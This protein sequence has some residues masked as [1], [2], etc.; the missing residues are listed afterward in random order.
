M[1]TITITLENKDTYIDHDGVLTVPCE[2]QKVI[3]SHNELTSLI[4]P[5]GIKMLDCTYNELT[6]LVVPK[7][8]QKLWCSGNK[9]TSLIVPEGVQELLCS[10]N[11]LTSLV[12]PKGIRIFWCCWNKLEFLELPD[13]LVLLNIEGNKK[14]I[15][16]PKEYHSK[17]PSE[18]MEYCKEH[19]FSQKLLFP[20][21]W[22]ERWNVIRLMYIAHYKEDLSSSNFNMIPIE[23]ITKIIA[24]YVLT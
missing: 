7:G 2:T 8:M 14:L 4:I 12:V 1:S 19:P 10:N 3:C 22:K 18:I 17:M 6:S 16:P 15:Y 5:E 9:L 11:K 13:S 21:R 24:R 20:K 23:V